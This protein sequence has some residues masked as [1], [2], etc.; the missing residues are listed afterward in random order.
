MSDES[1]AAIRAQL[2]EW[3]K[4]HRETYLRSGGARGH[5]E[6][7]S[8]AGGRTYSAHC[9]IKYTG[10]KSGRVF[11]KPLCYSVVGGEVVVVASRGGADRHPEWYLNVVASPQLHFQVATEAFRATWREPRGA[12]RE[13]VWA[14]MVDDFPFYANYQASTSRQ[15][16][17]VMMTAVE[18]VGAFKETDITG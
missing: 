7:L 15:I 5:I 9:L 8:S 17:L 18:P 6:D 12:E 1:S 11:I 3:M 13:R 14:H 16:P 2:S 4:E 10:R